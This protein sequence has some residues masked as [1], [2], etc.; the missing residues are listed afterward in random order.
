MEQ[1]KMGAAINQYRPDYAIPPG[2]ILEEH[3]EARGFSQAEFARRCGRSAKLISEIVHGKAPVEPD[4]ALQFERVLGLGANIWLGVE[5]KYRLHLARKAE[6]DKAARSS[7][8]LDQFPVAEL[9]KRGIIRKPES[10]A[11]VMSDMLSFFGVA[12]VEAWR[13]TYASTNV[14]YR[15]SPRFNSDEAVLATWLRLGEIEAR[16]QVCAEYNEGRFKQALREIR[17]LTLKPFDEALAGAQECCNQAGV[18]L[19]PVKPFPRMALSGAAQWLS[20]R[21]A[22]ILLSARHKTNDHLWFTLFHEAAH[23]L[24]H[25]KKGVFVDGPKL[26]NNAA[27]GDTEEEAN[28]WATH[29]LVPRNEWKDF[30][31]RC[32]FTKKAVLEFA[33]R[34]GIAPGILVGMLQ[35]EGY[36]PWSHLN[37]LKVQL[38]WQGEAA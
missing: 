20:P 15:H 13:T 3:L 5:N 11:N 25:S 8:W 34:Q 7:R 22:I 29:A 30:V 37:G 33:T 2:W 27:D 28:A 14:A 21:K 31:A 24:L 12:S 38:D 32:S 19:T 26:R 35:H 6:S 1:N 36:V 18:A 9:A 4:T 23:I 17:Y 10:D 16:K